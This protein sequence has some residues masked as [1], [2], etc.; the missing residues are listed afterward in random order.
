MFCAACVV[1]I[2]VGIEL[3][4]RLVSLTPLVWVCIISGLQFIV[5][6]LVVYGL[7]L[8]IVALLD[9]FC[10]KCMFDAVCCNSVVL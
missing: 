5:F 9:W 7:L 10:L 4:L 3:T 6:G 8:F 1:Y 2:V